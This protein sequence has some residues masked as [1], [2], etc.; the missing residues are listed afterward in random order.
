MF[1]KKVGRFVVFLMVYVD[2]LLMKG[3][4]ESYI[5]SIKKYFNKGFDMKNMGHLRYYMGI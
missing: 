5:A 3:N 4:N 1:V 2:D